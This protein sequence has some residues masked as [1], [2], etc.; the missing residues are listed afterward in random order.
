MG[1]QV[2]NFHAR[3]HMRNHTRRNGNLVQQVKKTDG[4]GRRFAEHEN[5]P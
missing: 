2:R 3:A 1:T 4:Y 5:Q